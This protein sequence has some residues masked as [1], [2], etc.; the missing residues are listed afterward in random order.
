LI[1]YYLLQR[2][3]SFQAAGEA[4][5]QLRDKDPNYNFPA[6]A[7]RY[8]LKWDTVAETIGLVTLPCEDLEKDI[9][10]GVVS[11][12][13]LSLDLLQAEIEGTIT[14]RQRGKSR[15]QKIAQGD[16]K[17]MNEADTCREY[18]LPKIQQAGWEQSPYSIT[19]KRTFTDGRIIPIGNRIERGK[20]KRADYILQYRRDLGKSN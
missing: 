1:V 14:R 9:N 15:S 3:Y 13:A 5:H 17:N 2:G 18:V 4:L 7:N 10:E 20:Q 19:E 11:V 6:N 8:L 16:V 12:T